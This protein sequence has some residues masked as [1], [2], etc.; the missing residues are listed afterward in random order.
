MTHSFPAETLHPI[1]I[2]NMSHTDPAFDI[3]ALSGCPLA[4][5]RDDVTQRKR[6]PKLCDTRQRSTR[7]SFPEVTDNLSNIVESLRLKW[8]LL[9]R[10]YSS[11]DPTTD[12]S[13]PRD[14]SLDTSDALISDLSSEDLT[15]EQ[16]PGSVSAQAEEFR[17][18]AREILDEL[19]ALISATNPSGAFLTEEEIEAS[20]GMAESGEEGMHSLIEFYYQQ[21]V[22]AAG[23]ALECIASCTVD[24]VLTKTRAFLALEGYRARDQSHLRSIVD[25]IDTTFPKGGAEGGELS[26]QLTSSLVETHVKGRLSYFQKKADKVHANNSILDWMSGTQA[27]NSSMPTHR[28]SLISWMITMPS[29]SSSSSSDDAADSHT[30]SR[31]RS[32]P[33]ELPSQ[34]IHS[35]TLSDILEPRQS[36]SDITFSFSRR[37]SSDA[38]LLMD[39]EPALFNRK[40]SDSS[41]LSSSYPSYS[42]ELPASSQDVYSSLEGATATSEYKPNLLI[43]FLRECSNSNTQIGNATKEARESVA[44]D[45]KPI[46]NTDIQ[47][48]NITTEGNTSPQT[49]EGVMRQ[50]KSKGR[51]LKQYSSHQL[52]D[53]NI[54]PI[55][56]QMF[57]DKHKHERPQTLPTVSDEETQV[58]KV[59]QEEELSPQSPVDNNSPGVSGQR[60]GS[61]GLLKPSRSF[62]EGSRTR[63]KSVE[64]LEPTEHVMPPVQEMDSVDPDEQAYLREEHKATM[65]SQPKRRLKKPLLSSFS[66]DVGDGIPDLGTGSVTMAT[67]AQ[68]HKPAPEPDSGEQ[69]D[70]L[71]QDWRAFQVTFEAD[72]Y[73]SR[74]RLRQSNINLN[75][76]LERMHE[77]ASAIDECISDLSHASSPESFRELEEALRSNL[78][79]LNS[80][81]EEVVAT[82]QMVGKLSQEY[83]D[84]SNFKLCFSYVD[85]LQSRCLT[86]D[87]SR[88]DHRMSLPRQESTVSNSSEVALISED[89]VQIAIERFISQPAQE[90]RWP[91]F[92]KDRSQFTAQQSQVERELKL[93]VQNYDSMFQKR[94]EEFNW[95]KFAIKLIVSLLTLVLLLYLTSESLE[96]STYTLFRNLRLR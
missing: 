77:Y 92:R 83:K 96:R 21:Q 52:L 72:M 78:N 40:L 62:E 57:Q 9:S 66:F 70:R 23:Y 51:L 20:Q 3:L 82:A 35:Q 17:G 47:N 80:S 59:A 53:S 8:A 38:G 81:L 67:P 61:R 15:Q 44:D 68:S 31:I 7:I 90:R 41:R 86:R 18:C 39:C 26:H 6:P 37:E 2:T 87:P 14:L 49:S 74:H 12:S 25:T 22:S 5:S 11:R 34:L 73:S 45:S 75:R 46:E 88:S 64:F 63:T 50:I 94:K 48:E 29:S 16:D 93:V 27:S 55:P 60:R 79:A 28:M 42:P 89:M 10:Q 43:E 65:A 30:I 58:A 32:E 69:F 4:P 54:E 76:K 19:E 24:A 33:G 95:I 13:F 85:K 84:N 56:K 1:A 36:I 91:T 71:E